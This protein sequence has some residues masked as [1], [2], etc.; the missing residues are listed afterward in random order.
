VPTTPKLP[1]IKFGKNFII[2]IIMQNTITPED[3]VFMVSLLR[4]NFIELAF[5]FYKSTSI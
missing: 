4:I 1:A 2:I 5:G 3:I